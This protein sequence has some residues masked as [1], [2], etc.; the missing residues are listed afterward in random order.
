M[1][2]RCA[3]SAAGAAAAPIAAPATYIARCADAEPAAGRPSGPSPPAGPAV[4][5]SRPWHRSW[6]LPGVHASRSWRAHDRSGCRH[7]LGQRLIGVGQSTQRSCGAAPAVRRC[8]GNGVGHPGYRVR[9]LLDLRRVDVGA[10]NAAREQAVAP[11][12]R[13]YRLRGQGIS[14]GFAFGANPVPCAHIR[15]RVPSP[16]PYRPDHDLVDCGRCPCATTILP[17]TRPDYSVVA[18]RPT[19]P[20]GDYSLTL[21]SFGT[22]RIRRVDLV[23]TGLSSADF[24]GTLGGTVKRPLTG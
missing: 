7:D 2:R 18:R 11:G 4:C 20:Q 23:T 21:S 19:S 14:Q 8:G 15:C 22:T 16:R 12:Q 10:G 3:G 13:R 6:R 17:L 1:P 24:T 9:I 5:R